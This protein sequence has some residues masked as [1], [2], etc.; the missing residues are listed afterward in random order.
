VPI[1]IVVAASR[2]PFATTTLWSWDSVLYARAL[3]LGYHQGIDIADQRPQAPGYFFYVAIAGLVRQ[4]THDSNTALVALSIVASGVAAATAFLVARRFAREGAAAVAALA[5]GL[6]PL[7]WT[8]GETA[9]PYALLALGSVAVAGAF[10]ASRGDARRTL[11]ASLVWGLAGGFRQDL[12]IVLGA[13]WLWTIAPL[14]WRDRGIAALAVTIGVLFWLVPSVIGSGGID[15]YLAAL[16]AQTGRVTTMSPVAAGAP[17]LVRN[18]ALSVYGLFWGSLAI[19]LALLVRGLARMR[20]LARSRDATFFV[21]WTFP[22]LVFYTL[23]HTGDPGYVLSVLPAIFV[24]F[25]AWLGGIVLAR[26]IANPIAAAVVLAQA[27]FFLVPGPYGLSAEV[28][29]AHDRSVRELLAAAAATPPQG[30][31]VAAQAGYLTAAYY[32]RDRPVRFSGAAPEVLARD[33]RA[34]GPPAVRTTVIV[35]DGGVLPNGAVLVTSSLSESVRLFTV[36]AG[37]PYPIPL[38]DLGLR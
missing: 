15:G 16:A 13:L 11:L 2:L 35:F 31:I 38:Y 7:A 33:A 34:E 5:L 28:L 1:A 23:V 6:S 22:A 29:A 25:A 9:M 24:A 21:L 12:V 19:G 18:L 32:V 3:E 8:F 36:D 17:Q 14:G 10:H 30:S 4:V 20:S 26:P 27:A 37:A